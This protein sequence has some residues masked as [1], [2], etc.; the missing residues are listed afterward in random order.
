MY[1]VYKNDLE[2]KFFIAYI[3][4]FVVGLGSWAFHMT[5]LYNMQLFDELPM[6][7]GL[8]FAI[9]LLT[10][11]KYPRSGSQLVSNPILSLFLILF[12]ITFTLFYLYYPLPVVQNL[13][14]GLLATTSYLI[15]IHM[16]RTKRCRL[17]SC[18]FALSFTSY[19]VGF[20]LWNVDKFYCDN[21]TSF[22]ETLPSWLSPTTQLHAWWHCFAGY[23]TYLSLMMT[24]HLHYDFHP[25]KNNSLHINKCGLNIHWEDSQGKLK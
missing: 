23:G 2:K 9:Y 5:L 7:W 15:Q 19:I 10:G 12:C 20:S 3:M 22:R 25:R 11:I 4:L 21:L 16:I 24:I 18:L 14:F 13:S 1:G 17:C 8:C 6:V